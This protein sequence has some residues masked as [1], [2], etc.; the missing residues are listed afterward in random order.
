MFVFSLHYKEYL[1]GKINKE[2]IDPITI[3]SNEELERVVSREGKTMAQ[4]NRETD[5]AYRTR[6]L[7]VKNV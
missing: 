1:V 5:P 3:M 2:A 6:L 4:K 7:E